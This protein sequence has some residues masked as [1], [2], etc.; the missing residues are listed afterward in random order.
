MLFSD[1]KCNTPAPGVTWSDPLLKIATD[2]AEG[3]ALLHSSSFVHRDVKPDNVLLT[4]TFGAKIADLGESRELAEDVTMTEVG[5]PVYSA[6]EMFRGKP[7]NAHRLSH[8][9]K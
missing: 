8:S 5:T 1:R 9:D 2:V 3:L 7:V 4:R 6:P